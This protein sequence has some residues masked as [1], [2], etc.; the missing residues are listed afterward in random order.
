MNKLT[1]YQDFHHYYKN[2][3]TLE[4]LIKRI[5]NN[6]QIIFVKCGDGEVECMKVTDSGM[7]IVSYGQ[8]CDNDKYFPELSMELKAAFIYF[9]NHNIYN[10]IHI[11]KWHHRPESDYLSKLYYEINSSNGINKVIPFTNYH[12]VMNDKHGLKNNHM[13][14]FVKSLKESNDYIKIVISN[15]DNI[16]LK[17]LFSTPFFVETPASCL[18]LKIDEITNNINEIIEK[19]MKIHKN[20]RIMLLTSCGLSAKVLIYRLFQKYNTLSAIDLGSSF[21]LLCKKR[22]TRT[23]QIEYSYDEIYEYYKEL[24]KKNVRFDVKD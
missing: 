2:K 1:Y 20:K 9:I 14:H 4:D 24:L 6:E 7:D 15:Q 3:F 10:N 19:E 11:G 17:E 13:Y 18:Y 8:N 12:L 16:L 5:T 22:V 21:D 23:Y